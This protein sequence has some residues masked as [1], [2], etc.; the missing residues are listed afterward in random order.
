MKPLDPASSPSLTPPLKGQGYSAALPNPLPL[1]GR[2]RGWGYDIAPPLELALAA[3]ADDVR[4]I[5]EGSLGGYEIS[6]EHGVRLFGAQ[7]A[8]LDALLRTADHV[9]RERVGDREI[10]RASCRERV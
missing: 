7:D 1:E 3:A 2:G 5:L 10:G 4:R 8:D 9:R 6:R